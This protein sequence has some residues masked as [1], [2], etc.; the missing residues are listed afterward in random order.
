MYNIKRTRKSPQNRW[1]VKMP[2]VIHAHN[3]A[4]KLNWIIVISYR[5]YVQKLNESQGNT[6]IRKRSNKFL[7][8]FK[9]KWYRVTCAQSSCTTVRNLRIEFMMLRR[10]SSSEPGL[11]FP[12][13]NDRRSWQVA[14]KRKALR[15][16][17]A[18][19]CMLLPFEARIILKRFWN[20][21]DLNINDYKTLGA[22]N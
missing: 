12:L 11:Q 7:T 2:I 21:Q 10:V 3:N 1:S 19:G 4:Q 16:T 6:L 13:S 5:P 22:T 20:T 8:W 15:N 18:E 14:V 17:F 9:N